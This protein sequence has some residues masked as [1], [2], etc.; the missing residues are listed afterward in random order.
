MEVHAHHALNLL[1]QAAAMFEGSFSESPGEKTA[2][3]FSEL[4]QSFQGSDFGLFFNQKVT[5]RSRES[6]SVHDL[7]L[8]CGELGRF[9]LRRMRVA[10]PEPDLPE[11][12]KPLSALR[13][14]L[15]SQY[16]ARRRSIL[17][18][19]AAAEPAAL[20][21][22][23]CSLP[24][25][26]TFL[27]FPV[28]KF[29]SVLYSLIKRHRGSHCDISCAPALRLCLH[30]VHHRCTH[31]SSFHCPCDRGK[32][33]CLLPQWT[34][35]FADPPPIIR[36]AMQSFCH[37][38]FPTYNVGILA[39]TS[40]ISLMELRLRSFPHAL[41]DTR[42][43]TLIHSA[44]FALAHALPPDA[45]HEKRHFRAVIRRSLTDRSTN[46]KLTVAGFFPDIQTPLRRY[47]FLR[48]C[49]ILEHCLSGDFTGSYDWDALLH[50]D[51]LCV[52]FG[53]ALEGD[54]GQL[55]PYTFCTLPDTFLGFFQP[56][57]SLS[58]SLRDPLLLSLATGDCVSGT[59]PPQCGEIRMRDIAA[60]L[61]GTY[62]PMLVIRGSQA[63]AGVY[64]SF[65][66]QR[67]YMNSS[68]P[69]YTDRFGDADI[70][71]R[72]GE[73]L[74]LSRDAVE[75]EIDRLL[76]HAWTDAVV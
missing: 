25:G 70:G 13:A 7:V 68:N 59:D 76:S 28:L 41:D 75:R 46:I 72:R 20:A 19:T 40:E 27:G 49:A 67:Q 36:E 30:A 15:V 73:V 52:H 11:T 69:I 65:E 53:V 66:W 63:N 17:G 44:Y 34:G 31:S 23:V 14:S 21:C 35:G 45:R 48:R 57:W 8:R 47:Y 33:N 39:L 24:A 55:P 3:S 54:P 60:K 74:R 64:I 6:E 1:V 22:T 37:V 32:R 12:S 5:F 51:A 62:C 71:F 38:A 2:D 56:P 16:A 50:W 29:N 61:H 18:D 4:V 26:D 42:F 9:V 58:R 10:A 43:L